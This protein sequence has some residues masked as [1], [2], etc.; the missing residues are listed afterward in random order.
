MGKQPARKT[1]STGKKRRKKKSKGFRLGASFWIMLVVLIVLSIVI[2]QKPLEKM[3][4]GI[5]F[6]EKFKQEDKP[7]VV[8]DIE[9]PSSKKGITSDKKTAK[10]ETPKDDG[11]K[12]VIKMGNQVVS[13]DADKPAQ[14]KQEPPKQIKS[15]LRDSSLYF[16]FF[17][18]SGD[19]KLNKITRKVKVAGSPL[20]AVMDVLL[21]GATPDEINQGYLSLIPPGTKLKSIRVSDG[22]ATM[23]FSEEFM[24]N[25]FGTEGMKNQ[26][27]QVIY[28]ACEFPTVQAVQFLIDGKVVPYMSESVYTE[29]PLTKSSF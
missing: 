11:K 22:I 19:I 3:I 28:T 4:T 5:K 8:E 24:F 15:T 25:T 2:W 17:S 29:K 23:D 20:Q 9:T 27:K 21:E 10:K 12:T 16:V 14:K 13:S 1:K 6:F 7:L 26:L 18:G